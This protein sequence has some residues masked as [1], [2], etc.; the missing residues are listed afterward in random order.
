MV[1]E[2]TGKDE[3]LS[4]QFKLVFTIKDTSTIPFLLTVHKEL[5]L[6]VQVLL[7]AVLHQESHKD[8]C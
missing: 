5:F 8:H 2:S 1:T 6:M 7:P 3:I 4:K